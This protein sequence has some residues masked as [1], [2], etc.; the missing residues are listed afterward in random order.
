MRIIDF[1]LSLPGEVIG[2]LLAQ[3]GGARLYRP[4]APLEAPKILFVAK[5]S[6]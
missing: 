3:V 5:K 6:Y 2:Q 4:L 1:R